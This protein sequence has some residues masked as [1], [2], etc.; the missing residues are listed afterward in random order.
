ML[1]SG[2]THT[3]VFYFLISHNSKAKYEE[4]SEA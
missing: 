3:H 1:P 4:Q 2:K